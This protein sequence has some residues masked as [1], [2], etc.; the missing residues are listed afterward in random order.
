[1]DSQTTRNIILHRE[2]QNHQLPHDQKNP[3]WNLQIQQEHNKRNRRKKKGNKTI[4]HPTDDQDL[5]LQTSPTTLNLRKPTLI[6]FLHLQQPRLQIMFAILL[7]PAVM[8]I[9]LPR[10][11]RSLQD[12]M[13]MRHARD[14]GEGF[15]RTGCGGSA[16]L[17]WVGLWSQHVCFVV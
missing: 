15:D 9:Q 16:L 11:P 7:T 6:P 17:G 4:S 13:P 3:I 2:S 8:T 5:L 10:S 1:M 12:L 14:L